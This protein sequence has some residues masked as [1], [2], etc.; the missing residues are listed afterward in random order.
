MKKLLIA[1]LLIG[2]MALGQNPNGGQSNEDQYV[3]IEYLGNLRARVTSK[4]NCAV[5]HKIKIDG[6]T[7]WNE[8]IAALG[9]YDFDVQLNTRVSVTPSVNCSTG[10]GNMGQVELKFTANVLPIKFG[11]FK[12][13]PVRKN[14][15]KISFEVYN[16]VPSN[17]YHLQMSRNGNTWETI[18]VQ[19]PDEL[20]PNKIYSLVVEIGAKTTKVSL[21]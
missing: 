10:E 4:Q 9:H 15:Y 12:A 3:K 2:H 14:T 7:Q 13:V 19:F 21:H 1:S 5:I 18:A 20:Q 16:S 17:T 6:G 11:T 8:S